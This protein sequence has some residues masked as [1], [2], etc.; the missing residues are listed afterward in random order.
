[1]ERYLAAWNACGTD[2]MDQLSTDDIVWA[3]PALGEPAPG[4]GAALAPVTRQQK[5]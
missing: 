1:V 5:R 2:A 3:D 4:V